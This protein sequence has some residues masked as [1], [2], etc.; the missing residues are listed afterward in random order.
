[1]ADSDELSSSG[2]HGSLVGRSWRKL[3]SG[4]QGITV[5]DGDVFCRGADERRSQGEGMCWLGRFK[6]DLGFKNLH[7]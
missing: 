7:F 2:R 3:E 1:V 6:R 4:L 5:G